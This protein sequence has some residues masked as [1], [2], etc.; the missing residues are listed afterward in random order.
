MENLYTNYRKRIDSEKCFY[1]RYLHNDIDWNERMIGII[2]AGGGW[3][4]YF[5]DPAYTGNVY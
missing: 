3:K 5:D 4:N 2:G 1:L